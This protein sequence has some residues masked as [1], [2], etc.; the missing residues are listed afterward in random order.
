MIKLLFISAVAASKARFEQ[1]PPL[2]Y[3]IDPPGMSNDDGGFGQ[4]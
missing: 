2:S 4:L 1:S 3:K